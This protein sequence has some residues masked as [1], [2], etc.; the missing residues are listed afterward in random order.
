MYVLAKHNSDGV[1]SLHGLTE[2]ED[3]AF[4]W[5]AANQLVF[6][7]DPKDVAQVSEYTPWEE[8]DSE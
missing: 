5:F 8:D 6:D 3:V 7:I 4:A 2:Q 1:L